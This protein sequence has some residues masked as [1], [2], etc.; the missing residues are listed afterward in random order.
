MEVKSDRA[1]VSDKR[2]QAT[3]HP[4]F[5]ARDI[6]RPKFVLRASVFRNADYPS[7][8]N[9]RARRRISSETSGMG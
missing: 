8:T 7:C 5:H 9:S 3:P 1:G 4:T 2:K 6:P